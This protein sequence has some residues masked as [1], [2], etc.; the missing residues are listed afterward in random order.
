MSSFP[1]HARVVVV[2]GGI[3]GCSTAYH[4][5]K[6]GWKDVVL[7]ERAQLTCGSTFHAAGLVGQ[8]RSSARI[9]RLL[10][11]SVALYESLEAETGFATGW[12]RCGGLRL[13]CTAERMA[14][15]ARQTTTARSFGL[16]MHLLTPQEAK[17]LWPPMD[18]SGVRGA[19]FLPSDGAVGPSDVT[20]ALAR[21]ARLH[22]ARVIQDCPVT[23]VEVVRG[24]VAGVGTPRGP[25]S[26]EV[27][28]NC[29]GQWARAF[30]QMA[31]VTIPLASMQH[32]FMVT[33]PIPGLPRDLPTLRDPD[34][35]TYFKEEVGGLVVGGYERDPIPWATRG[36]PK[37][38]V[39]QLLPADFDHFMPLAELALRRVPALQT[40]G[41]RRLYN[42]PEAFTPD[43]MFI[44]G[45]APEVAGYFVGTGFNAFGIAAGGGAGK[46]LAAWI[47]DG[48]PPYDL[49]AADIRRFGPH[50]GD[51]RWVQTRTQELYGK[52]YTISWPHE[53]HD[54]GRPL[55]RSPLYET[56]RAGGACFGEKLGWERPNWFA[57]EGVEPAD[58]YSFGRQNWFPYVGEE[59]RA[60]RER[61]ALFDQT[62]F[63]K[64]LVV[65][66]DAEAALSHICA[67][68]VT[69][70]P[71]RLTYTQMLNRRGTIECDLTVARI[72]PDRFYLTSGTAFAT[73]D[74]AWIRRNIP[75]GMDAHVVDVTSARSVVAIMGPR[76]R[77]V[78]SA[79][80][81]ADVSNEA[82]PFATVREI[83][84]A[85]ARVR[86]LRITYVG[87]LGWELHVPGELALAVYEAL[88][89]AGQ[90]HGIVDAGYRAIESLRLEK[91]Y[92][93]WG[94]DIGPD[95]TPLE[96]GL[97]WAVKWKSGQPFL[98]R[99]A[100]LDQKAAGL[101]QRLACFVVDDPAVVLL[102]RETIY[103][104]G[105]RVGW[106]TS[107]G[108][109]HTVGRP[110]GYGY[111][112]DPAGVDKKYL[113][114]GAYELEVA[115]RRV[116][117]RLRL[118]ALY[119]PKNRE[120]KG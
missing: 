97:G 45:E 67:G 37:D 51:P 94:A 69:R 76:A 103:R 21:G 34:R 64:L 52:H 12:K 38:F 40:A 99:E 14:E 15:L 119:D 111:V 120:I 49:W 60:V 5:A 33:V 28:V 27:V 61:V 110:I 88:R 16:E 36:I 17:D 73:H 47:M 43:G 108:F 57:P 3:M 41:I 1:S 84:I 48:E 66:R 83:P 107:G 7:L 65:G 26:C 8:L 59:H 86:A 68:D 98:G 102:G 23:S 42:G 62:S 81:S 82:F 24:R 79:V 78:L 9:T 114:S 113:R 101:V 92:R 106:L 95:Y 72:A 4:L 20:M 6:A 71:G 80:T 18:L 11:D 2:G 32:Q 46:A 100:L 30:G 105:E 96:A 91:G 13:A 44:L 89:E 116:P 35:L 74:S 53:E 75:R 31:G 39:F 85:G 10:G 70:P 22:G 104:D 55:R 25:I 93:L 50:H 56:L 109:G 54:S 63:T 87:A 90:A 29:C 77:D 19:A 115:T 112:V 58:L 117:A 118:R